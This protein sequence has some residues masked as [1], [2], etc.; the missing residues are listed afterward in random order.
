MPISASYSQIIEHS[1]LHSLQDK[2]IGSLNLPI[3]LRVR[4]G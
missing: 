3:C 1:D 2:S 4:R